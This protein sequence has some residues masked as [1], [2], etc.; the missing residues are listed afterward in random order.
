M[1]VLVSGVSGFIGR[2]LVPELLRR[3]HEVAG[4]DLVP[5]A[6]AAGIRFARG[7]AAHAGRVAGMLGDCDHF[8][9]LAGAVGPV[10]WMH[11]YPYDAL[12]GNLALA[13]AACDAAIEA[14]SADSALRK[15]TFV[16][17]SMV[18]ARASRW[19]SREGDEREIPPPLTG[20]GFSKLATEWLARAARDQ[21]DLPFTIVRPFNVTGPGEP[22]GHAHVVTDLIRGALGGQD[23]L[24]VLGD[25]SQ[26]RYLTHVDDV[27]RG[28]AAAMESD[29]ALCEDFNLAGRE[30][31]TVLELAQMAWDVAHPGE[32]LRYECDPAFPLDVRTRIPDSSKAERILGWKATVP[33]ATMVAEVAAAERAAICETGSA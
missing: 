4:I 3:G 1:R 27:A 22:A 28:I 12:R 21:H 31:V 10:G 14:R 7:D 2:S 26:V 6:D 17:S 18:Y 23:P 15:V 32:P 5:P 24:R 33:V 29:A 30:P 19:P 25:G 8:I 20:Y 16:S 9:A 11:D 13:A